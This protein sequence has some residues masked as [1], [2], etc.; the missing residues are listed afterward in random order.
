MDAHGKKRLLLQVGETGEPQIQFL[1]ANGKAVKSI[2]AR[3]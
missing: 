1:D 2:S 3:P